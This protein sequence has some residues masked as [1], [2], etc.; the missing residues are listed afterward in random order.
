MFSVFECQN[1]N[2]NINEVDIQNNLQIKK[3]KSKSFRNLKIKY[4]ENQNDGLTSSNSSRDLR[5]FSI[6]EID[7]ALKLIML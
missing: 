3:G 6:A 5:Q 1:N 4:K 2:Y 7:I